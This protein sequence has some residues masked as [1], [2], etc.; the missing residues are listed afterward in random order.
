M[1]RRT[2]NQWVGAAMGLA[3]LVGT[4]QAQFAQR[5]IR[6]RQ[7]A[8]PGSVT[9]PYLFNDPTGGQ[10]RIYNGGWAQQQGGMSLIGQGAMLNVN[11]QQV[12]QNNNQGAIDAKTGEL[13]LTGMTANGL[14]IER[15]ILFDR[16]IGAL[17]YIDVLQNTQ[18]QE[19]T[20]NVMV[21]TTINFGLNGAQ[22]ITDPKK[23]DQNIAWVGQTGAGQCVLEVFAGKNAKM[24]PTINWPQGNNFVDADYSLAIPAGKKVAIMHLHRIVNTSEAGTQ[25]VEGLKESQLTKEIPI[26][27]RKLIVNF[28]A[29]QAWIG[30][31]EIL[32]G[33]LQDVIELHDGDQFKGTLKEPNYVLDTFYGP[34][35]LPAEQVI[36]MLSVGQ[37]RPRQLLVTL[38]GE[39]F[40]GHLKKETLDIQLSSGQTLQIPLSQISR[41]GYRKRSDEPEEW[42]FEKPMVL[43]RTGER[44]AIK[45]LAAPLQV[46]TRY[47]TIALKPDK[48]ADILFQ[49]EQGPMH[50]IELT[51]GSK[52]AGIVSEGQF[53]VTFD[54]QGQTVKFPASAILRLQL[55]SKAPE[56]DE[57][58][59]TI[60]LSNEDVL[61]GT[62]EGKLSLDTAFDTISINT[63][64]IRSMK[65]APESVQDVQVGLWDGTT[66][67]GQLHE[68][69]LACKLSSGVEVKVPVALLDSYLQPQPQPSDAML[70]RIK[71]LVAQLNADDWHDRDRAQADL[72]SMGPVAEG[73]LKQMR[74]D[75][76]IE[77]QK[78]IDLILAKFEEQ[79]KKEKPA[80]GAAA[81]AHANPPAEQFLIGEPQV[82]R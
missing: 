74:A 48:I 82:E 47:G 55:V 29:G 68:P 8:G 61:V 79:R 58:A 39:I 41:A 28:P 3:L 81:A 67:S 50:Q 13:V 4:A 22:F 14:S 56:T 38:N 26:A 36:G 80:V 49:S 17:R 18:N 51:D 20:F 70:T 53:E 34:V 32:R 62:I 30:D 46:V 54:A 2:W 37:F 27:L 11:G 33:D 43:L 76:P 21:R 6:V 60:H 72:T 77:A 52:F 16:T 5:G 42:K 24:V 44:I 12:N 75:Q 57:L 23:K 45:P 40:G 71:S 7:P 31:L 78:T 73:V 69:E 59:P 63:S 19:Q 1:N 64:Q 35:T 25:F 66:F 10:W 15:R 65:R 9:L